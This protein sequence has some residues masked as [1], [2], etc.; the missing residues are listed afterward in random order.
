MKEPPPPAVRRYIKFIAHRA[1]SQPSHQRCVNLKIPKNLGP[2]SRHP[3]HPQDMSI[4][5][6]HLLPR[7]VKFMKLFSEVNVKFIV[8]L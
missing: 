8:K 4:K 1:I 7:I 5:D 3:S 6:A 2:K